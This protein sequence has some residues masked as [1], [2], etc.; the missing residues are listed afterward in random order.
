M[1]GSVGSSFPD[2]NILF[3]AASGGAT[4]AVQNQLLQNQTQQQTLGEHEIEMMS[5]AAAG[6]LG[7]PPEQRAAAYSGA[8]SDLRRYG[9]AKNAP[10]AYPGDA[11]IQRVANMGMPITQQ[12]QYG[13]IQPPGLGADL[14]RLGLGGGGGASAPGPYAAPTGGGGTPL[15]PAPAGAYGQ[16]GK[17]AAAEVPKEYLPF[18]KEA[19]DRTGIP[20]EL[21][22]A[23]HRQESG[24]NANARGRA[25]EI[26]IGQ[27]MPSTALAP[28]YG[29][30]PID[31]ATLTDPRTNI[32]FSAD[33]MKARMR[34]DP[35]DPEV[36][37]RALVAYNGGGDPNYVQN[38][39]RY[40]PG[41]YP[42]TQTAAIQAQPQA[43]PPPTQQAAAQP[44]GAPGATPPAPGS[45]FA[46]PGAPPSPS[47]TA[48]PAATLPPGTAP[49][50]PQGAT[51]PPQGAPQVATG[52]NSPQF[53]EATRL[54]AQATE[55]LTKYPMSPQAKAMAAAL[56]QR[57]TLLMQTDS[58]V[59]GPGGVQV[60]TLT[61]AQ[62][63][64]AKPLSTWVWN[65]QQGA[66][67]DTTGGS[68]PVTPS[69]R[70]EA[71][72]TQ[73]LSSL[74]DKIKNG[75]ATPQE[76]AQYATA[77]E[78]YR[79]PAIHENPITHGLVRL[80]ARELPAGMPEP[81]AVGGGPAAPPMPAGGQNVTEGM[82][83]AQQ[84]SERK[85][86][87]D[88]ADAEKKGYAG[89]SESLLMLGGMNNAAEVMNRTPGAF[90][91]TGPGGNTRLE[92]AKAAN[93]ALALFGE[94]PAFDPAQIS[95]WEA[96]N[97]ATRLMGFKVVSSSFGASREAASIIQSAT[98][99]V[100]SAENSYLGFRLVSSGIE[101]SLQRGQEMYEYKAQLLAQGKPLS[102]AEADF[103]KTHPVQNYEQRAVAN[104]VPDD[105]VQHLQQNP[106]TVEAFN[107][108]FGPGIGQFILSGGR[109]GMGAA[110]RGR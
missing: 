1:S 50:A 76:Q 34:G 41:S 65:P 46:G 79:Q 37:R 84:A 53:Q 72:L 45:Q 58:V 98:S 94:K 93:T 96:L 62:E 54:Q 8:V 27:I 69:L 12:Y 95:S 28:G 75:T 89:G 21:L 5:R 43:T 63:S 15:T 11:A 83:P 26:G 110:M 10:D 18:Y 3:N 101:Q 73:T 97:K 91:A 92:L 57:A 14:Q 78:L 52:V 6:V 67:I 68:A 90:T 56:Q 39:T 70:T 108:H 80:N 103:N 25:G 42:Q 47:P 40:L 36:Q 13:I 48:P 44:Q 59:Q 4:A 23:Q 31:P 17:G 100:P 109:T 49:V 71:M 66:Y 24:F 38:V 2:Q 107:K 20:M 82:T 74:A 64:A 87:E 99:S 86:G 30:Q 81:P 60:H 29:M 9:Y 61:G 33:Y 32:N 85:A 88:F 51:P 16:G 106:D 102:G 77:A 22:I 55:L 19:S 35:R 7:L 104:A 105:I